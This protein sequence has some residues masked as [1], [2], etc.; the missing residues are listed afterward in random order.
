MFAF[1]VIS[2]YR[3]VDWLTIFGFSLDDISRVQ[4]SSVPLHTMELDATVY[5]PRVRIPWFRDLRKPDLNSPLVPLSQWLTHSEPR[6]IESLSQKPATDRFIKIGSEDA[7]AFPELLPGSIVRVRQRERG[8]LR[9]GAN[10]QKSKTLFLVE[11]SR[12]L[13]CAPIQR[14]DRSRFL[15]CSAQLPYAPIEF[16]EGKQAAILGAAD[17]EIRPLGVTEQPVVPPS[18]GRFWNP[19]AL[20]RNKRPPNLGELIRS[21]RE[22]SGL[23]FREASE[24]T[25]E[26]GQI[27]E[28][29]LCFCAPSSLSDYE[30]RTAPPRHAQKMISICSV[31]GLAASRYLQAAGLRLDEGGP[32]PM[33]EEFIGSSDGQEAKETLRPAS[34]FFEEMRNRF[35][36]FPFFLRDAL[37]SL[38]GMR[39]LSVRD[40]FWAGGASDFTHR[41]LLGC[42]FLVVDRRRKTPR[43]SL[44]SPTW[45]QP[46]YVLQTR[47]GHYL[48][49][50]CSLQ[51]GTLMLRSCLTGF[52]KVLR[53]RNRVDAEVIGKVTGAVRRLP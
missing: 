27:L 47:D 41:Y 26:I 8:P 10:G 32:L 1:S 25:A 34:Y 33:P 51:N 4:A 5:H 31:Y 28:E 3:F 13:S 7:F 11:H 35:G 30:T 9:V 6:Q 45:A 22:R 36:E 18:L 14:V 48:C 15:M 12:G 29:P 16:E 17:L 38:F 44:S 43:P 53:L 19:A 23:S 20:A 50:A 46:L 42:A 49:A 21:A 2:G 52:P 39:D 24:R 37:S 40:V